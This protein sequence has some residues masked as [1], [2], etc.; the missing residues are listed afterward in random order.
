MAAVPAEEVAQSGIGHR[1]TFFLDGAH[2]PESM[3]TSAEWFAGAAACGP[4]LPGMSPEIQRVLLFHCMQ[5]GMLALLTV[6][7][8]VDTAGAKHTVGFIGGPFLWGVSWLG[9]CLRVHGRC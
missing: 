6:V 4:G 1:L 7:C 5:V 9:L 8:L 2:T 3:A